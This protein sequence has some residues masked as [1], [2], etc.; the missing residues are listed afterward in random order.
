M[1]VSNIS[2]HT[3][4]TFTQDS[5]LI[6]TDSPDCLDLIISFCVINHELSTEPKPFLIS[7]NIR[8]DIV[9]NRYEIMMDEIK[10]MYILE[11]LNLILLQFEREEF[12]ESIFP[13][14]Y[15]H[16][17]IISSSFIGLKKF[18]HYVFKYD[19]ISLLFSI[20]YRTSLIYIDSKIVPFKWI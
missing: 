17:D 1:S 13:S 10:D 18:N 16:D 6:N 11:V 9:I 19:N 15:F 14:S 12:G 3:F 20:N 8:I 7:N 2:V 4:K 5:K